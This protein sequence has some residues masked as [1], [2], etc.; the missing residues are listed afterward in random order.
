MVRLVGKDVQR[1][2]GGVSESHRG[3][4]APARRLTSTGQKCAEEMRAQIHSVAV[5]K[6]SGSATMSTEAPRSLRPKVDVKEFVA[7]MKKLDTS[8]GE[9]ADEVTAERE[10]YGRGRRLPS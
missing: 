7:N 6:R 5:Q 9:I 3:G 1:Y 10:T 4:V 8:E 2:A